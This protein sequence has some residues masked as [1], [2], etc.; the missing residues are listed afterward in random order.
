[1]SSLTSFKIIIRGISISFVLIMAALFILF[2]YDLYGTIFLSNQSIFT[3]LCSLIKQA[4]LHSDSNA[5]VQLM[6]FFGEY[7]E[8]IIYIFKD[9]FFICVVPFIIKIIVISLIYYVFNRLPIPNAFIG[10]WEKRGDISNILGR[11]LTEYLRYH[12]FF[13]VRQFMHCAYNSE[14]EEYLLYKHSKNKHLKELFKNH[15]PYIEQD[16]K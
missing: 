15:D 10:H 7:G 2:C 1:M 5:R 12:R 16:S 13:T 6:Q 4:Y 8:T 11:N 3:T 14:M 9:A